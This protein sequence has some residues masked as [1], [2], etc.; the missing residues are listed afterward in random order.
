[1]AND[2][3][4][5]SF[6]SKVYLTRG[7]NANNSGFLERN[8]RHALDAHERELACD[9]KLAKASD[10]VGM[11]ERRRTRSHAWDFPSDK[12]M[13]ELIKTNKARLRIKSLLLQNPTKATASA[14]SQTK[15][16]RQ[17]EQ[18]KWLQE[19]DQLHLPC[20]IVATINDARSQPRTI[21]TAA[22]QG[23]ITKHGKSAF[24]ITFHEP[25]VLQADDLNMHTPSTTGTGKWKRDCIQDYSLEFGIHCH[26]TDDT[27]D[28]LS[29][30]ERKVLSES[31]TAPGHEGVVKCTWTGLPGLP[32][33]D[34][35]LTLHRVNGPHTSTLSYAAYVDMAWNKRESPLSTYNKVLRKAR[36]KPRQ[37]PKPS[38]HSER[39]G[40]K[41]LLKY[42]YR[43]GLETKGMPVNHLR[44]IFCTSDS[45]HATFERLHLHYLLR[46][47]HFQYDVVLEEVEDGVNLRTIRISHENYKHTPSEKE[48]EWEAPRR[49]FDIAA[50]LKG[51]SLW[52][53]RDTKHMTT[54]GPGRPRKEQPLVLTR[55]KKRN[56]APEEIGELPL[57]TKKRHVVPRVTGVEF[58]RTKSKQSVEPGTLLSDS[59]DDVDETW[60]LQRQQQHR[61]K[62]GATKIAQGFNELFNSHLNDE[63]QPQSDVLVR[64]AVVR[65][66]REYAR[67]AARPGWKEQFDDKLKLLQSVNIIDSRTVRFCQGK[68]SEVEHS[69]E[70]PTLV[71]DED[72]EQLPETHTRTVATLNRR[73]RENLTSQVRGTAAVFD[74]GRDA[75]LG[76]A[77][78]IIPESPTDVSSSKNRVRWAG[79]KMKSASTEPE[80]P[81]RT[82]T[83][84]GQRSLI[85]IRPATKKHGEKSTR[86]L[87]ITEF[88]KDNHSRTPIDEIQPSDLDFKKFLRSLDNDLVYIRAVDNIVCISNATRRPVVDENDWQEALRGVQAEDTGP[89]RFLLG[90]L[91]LIESSQVSTPRKLKRMTELSAEKLKQPVTVARRKKPCVCGE[92]INSLRNTIGCGNPRCHRDFHMPCVQLQ[93]RSMD[94]LCVD[95]SS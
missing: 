76:D 63:N 22:R 80:D 68:V 40:G 13:E 4:F 95:C 12:V 65:F 29:R 42:S 69:L 79:G 5:R 60:L 74:K 31:L 20:Q 10:R 34:E 30:L 62:F 71:A 78:T 16:A 81:R 35:P 7:L 73:I 70:G 8:L 50:H 93:R 48:F 67:E 37:L 15:R 46:H 44:C 2:I 56:A 75:E 39:A 77:Q 72:E 55:R 21:F 9:R 17:K 18:P 84:L 47:E 24:Q 92:Y 11:A 52:T 49:A 91:D 36:N 1:M 43:Q 85:C 33:P 82:D 28:F 89:I 6:V 51:T 38:E 94:W 19:P 23:T 45:E 54:K 83:P 57:C 61:A 53:A 64:D 87:P 41:T 86:E 3:E 58:Y 59:E 25:F 66:A 90:P 32:Q 88:T 27:A 26:D 14:D